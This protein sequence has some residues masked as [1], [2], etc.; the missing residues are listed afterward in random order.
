MRHSKIL[1]ITIKQLGYCF[2]NLVLVSVS[3]IVYHVYCEC[4]ISYETVPNT[5]SRP[6]LSVPHLRLWLLNVN[7]QKFELCLPLFGPHLEAMRG[8][9]GQWPCLYASMDQDHFKE[10]KD[11]V[12]QFSSCGVTAS[13][14]IWVSDRDAQK[15]LTGI[16]I[17]CCK[18]ID[19]ENST[20]L[21]MKGISPT[22][23][24]LQHLQHGWMGGRRL[25]YFIVPIEK[26]REQQI[27]SKNWILMAW[28]TRASV[29]TKLIMHLG[30][31]SLLWVN[32]ISATA[33][34]NVTLWW[35]RKHHWY[36][37]WQ[38]YTSF[39]PQCSWAAFNKIDVASYGFRD[40]K[41]PTSTV[42][43]L[44]P[45]N[46]HTGFN[47]F[48]VCQMVQ[49]TCLWGCSHNCTTDMYNGQLSWN[50]LYNGQL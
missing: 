48:G 16:W 3:H 8:L 23:V 6:T 30:V 7:H 45:Y 42:P 41:P 24:E 26:G 21:E 37:Q 29:A 25:K 19:Q 13:T 5:I 15:D 46:A 9:M 32:I 33:S 35:Q 22:V 27:S 10:I 40:Y 17:C 1:V 36:L 34:A 18:F 44:K 39:M 49:P 43:G 4:N 14:R 11:G 31:S 28:Y 20:E 12:N 47:K 50:Q 38:C 2:Q